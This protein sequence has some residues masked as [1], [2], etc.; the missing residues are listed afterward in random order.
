M[1]FELFVTL[2]HR[3]PPPHRDRLQLLQ[4]IRSELAS[5]AALDGLGAPAV[6][7]EE[8]LDAA[9]RETDSLRSL[10][11]DSK[12]LWMRPIERPTPCVLWEPSAI[13]RSMPCNRW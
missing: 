12:R 13:E 8:A 3:D 6:R 9:H 10:G 4:Q 5:V 2:G 7:L 1:G 11:A